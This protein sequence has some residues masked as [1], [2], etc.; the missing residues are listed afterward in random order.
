MSCWG[1]HEQILFSQGDMTVQNS[2]LKSFDWTTGRKNSISPRA[3]KNKEEAE[4]PPNLENSRESTTGSFSET[5]VCRLGIK[6]TDFAKSDLLS[7]SETFHFSGRFSSNAVTLGQEDF[8][9]L[10][11]VVLWLLC[12]KKKKCF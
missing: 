12:L 4:V 2:H 5:S 10:R 8:K 6:A 3:K 9:G 11:R 7:F 1:L